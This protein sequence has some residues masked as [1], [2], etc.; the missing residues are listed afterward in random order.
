MPESSTS[1]ILSQGRYSAILISPDAAPLIQDCLDSLVRSH[2]DSSERRNSTTSEA[3]NLDIATA[4][5]NAFLQVNVTGPVLADQASVEDAFLTAFR[6][7]ANDSTASLRGLRRKC[8]DA[9]TVDGVSPYP[10]IPLLEVFALARHI[11]QTALHLHSNQDPKLEPRLRWNCLRIDVWHYKLLTQPSLGGTAFTKA[12]QW[13]DVPSLQENIVAQIEKAEKVLLGED[14]S[15]GVEDKVEFLLEKAGASVILGQDS[16]AKAALEQAKAL[17]G[18]VYSLSGALGKRTKFQEKSTS[19]LVVL[20]KSGAAPAII[21]SPS[22]KSEPRP[23]ALL[24]NDDTL[25]EQIEFSKADIAPPQKSS[26]P[27]SLNDLAARP[28]DQPQLAPLDQIILLSDATIKDSFSPT[29]TLTAEEVMPFASR[30]LANKS[31]NWQIYTHAL[32]VRSRIE[33]HRSRTIERGILQ[34]Q[35]VV[36][37]VI[38][39]TTTN[40]PQA[41]SE[42]S[43]SSIPSISVSN[44][45]AAQ[46]RN[47]AQPTSFLP[48]P[49]Q[50]ESAP[51]Q[52]R[53][54]YV[55]ALFS[56]PKWHLESELAYGWAGIGSL[57]S[58]LEIFKRLR[59]WAEVALCLAAAGAS[60]AQDEDGRGSGGEDKARAVLRWQ[61]YQPTG[62]ETSPGGGAPDNDDEGDDDVDV[63]SLKSVDFMGP[64]RVPLPSNAPRLLCILGEVENEPAHFERAWE[65]SKHRFAR[66]QKALGEHYLTKR[67]WES[68]RESYALAAGV[69]R[70]SP[71][72]WSRLGDINLRLSRFA[73]AAEAFS[74]AIGAASD[75]I[76]GEDA[77]TWSNLGSALW[78]LCCE[79]MEEEEKEQ[80]EAEEKSRAQGDDGQMNGFDDRKNDDDAE[81]V[82]PTGG[83]GA[84]GPTARDQIFD[85]DPTKLLIQSLAAYKRGAKIANSNWRIWD[86]VITLASRMRP[87]PAYMDM[88]QAMRQVLRI[89]PTEAAIDVDVLRSLVQDLILAK[90]P[91]TKEGKY[92]P[93]RGTPTKAVVDLLEDVIVPLI[94]TRDDLWELVSK[95]RV[96]R[97]EYGAAVEASEKAWRAAMATGAVGVGVGASLGVDTTTKSGVKSDLEEV[98]MKPRGS[99]TEDVKSWDNVVHRTDELVSMLENYGSRVESIGARWKGK[100]RMAVRSVMGKGKERWE[101]NEGWKVLEGVQEGLK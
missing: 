29:D 21:L 17:N 39:D 11:F 60:A 47:S 3:P 50:G 76:G 43:D 2:T 78:S 36:D 75:V 1:T 46:P 51:P 89:R 63:N 94:T 20:A 98:R 58:A 73:D 67:D 18:F 27:D 66:A 70:L 4:A 6:V 14:S 85:R 44:S 40:R 64:E 81:S 56:P 12:A 82:T 92:N 61:L 8:L 9:L 32:L 77:R 53:L 15:R 99:W 38:A 25:L 41:N 5:L 34:M 28:D 35:A 83:S 86:N 69:N 55:H 88:V 19:Q 68:A 101:A 31:T 7:A 33:A 52:D 13:C 62:A 87:T 84:R 42:K 54:R 93:P 49:K 59:L 48:A 16:V 90:E 45:D 37:Q 65:V 80:K 23:D 72:V 97:R 24:L 100:A 74:R 26:L 22:P 91:E 10:H 79:V 95:E 57:V 30:V 96:W 71:E